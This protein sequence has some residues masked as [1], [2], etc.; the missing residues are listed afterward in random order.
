MIDSPSKV[1]PTIFLFCALIS[2]Q[3]VVD[4]SQDQSA[5]KGEAGGE[6]GRPDNCAELHPQPP[7][8]PRVQ[9]RLPPLRPRHQ[10]QPASHLSLQGRDGEVGEVKGF[11][12]TKNC[13]PQI[14]H[15]KV[16]S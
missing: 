5:H 2:K 9:V 12:P 15:G 16:Q 6:E 13:S 7:S 1:I 3:T 11:D 14:C 4:S 8:H 10:C